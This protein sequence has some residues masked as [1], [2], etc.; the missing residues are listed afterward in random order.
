MKTVLG[1]GGLG[2]AAMLYSKLLNLNIPIEDIELTHV[3]VPKILIPKIKEFYDTQ[4]LT[5]TVLQIDNYRDWMNVNK[6]NYD[7]FVDT[8]AYGENMYPHIE[9]IPFPELNINNSYDFDIV[10]SPSAGKYSERNFGIQEIMNLIKKN[11]DKKIVLIGTV[12]NSV[13]FDGL[14]ITNLLNKTS[15]QE[16]LNII[17]GSEYVIAPSGFISFIGCMMK[18]NVFSKD[19]RKEIE[20]NYYHNDWNNKFIKTLKEIEL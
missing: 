2:D 18:K 7:I 3:E 6:D 14:G 13:M 12:N 19:G 15:I 10:V 8:S 4:N 11:N 5:S 17:A 1:G 16:A 20:E 9:I